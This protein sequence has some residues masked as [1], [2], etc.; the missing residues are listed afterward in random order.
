MNVKYVLIPEELYKEIKAEVQPWLKDQEFAYHT[1][2]RMAE[3]VLVEYI[4]NK[5]GFT[6]FEDRAVY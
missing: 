1:G 5:R 6:T 3:Q 4:A 2:E